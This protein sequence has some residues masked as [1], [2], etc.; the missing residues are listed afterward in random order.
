MIMPSESD[1]V[2]GTSMPPKSMASLMC[3]LLATL[4]TMGNINFM[5]HVNISTC[6]DLHVDTLL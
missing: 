6:T 2:M 5:D 3:P 1:E 4:Y